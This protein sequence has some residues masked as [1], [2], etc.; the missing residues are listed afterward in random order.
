[1]TDPL[2]W[3]SLRS[4]GASAV[5]L[6][7]FATPHA[8]L[9][10]S[11]ADRLHQWLC[12]GLTG[13]AFDFAAMIKAFPLETLPAPEEVAQK[14]KSDKSSAVHAVRSDGEH[15]TIEYR[16]QYSLDDVTKPYGIAINLQLAYPASE[17]NVKT[18]NALQR[19]F[20]KPKPGMLGPRVAF[21]SPMFTGGDTPFNI[22]LWST[23]NLLHVEWFYKKD[24]ALAKLACR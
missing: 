10:A 15:W 17:E 8:A 11:D 21:G 23:T 7:L 12:T 20:G 5:A 3:Q 18:I 16:Y 9:A 13:D 6:A 1:M 24:L 4:H 14:P 2:R 22:D 19:S